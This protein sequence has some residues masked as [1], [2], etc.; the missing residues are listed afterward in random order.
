MPSA[1]IPTIPITSTAK[2][3]YE[4]DPLSIRYIEL[5]SSGFVRMYHFCL[6]TVSAKGSLESLK[7]N[8]LSKYQ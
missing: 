8:L 2:M 1:V 4:S 7:Y 5:T 6:A 3:S